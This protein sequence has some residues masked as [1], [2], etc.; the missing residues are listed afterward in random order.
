VQVVGAISK[1]LHSKD[2]LPVDDYLR[3]GMEALEEFEVELTTRGTTFF[4][5]KF[6]FRTVGGYFCC[7]G[8]LTKL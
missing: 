3:E 6:R 2:S 4:G 1:A 7:L 8:C 5:G